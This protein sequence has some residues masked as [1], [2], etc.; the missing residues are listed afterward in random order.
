M[1]K[2]VDDLYA[3]LTDGLQLIKIGALQVDNT[4]HGPFGGFDA[5]VRIKGYAGLQ[6]LAVGTTGLFHGLEILTAAGGGDAVRIVSP[7]GFGVNVD[8]YQSALRLYGYDALQLIAKGLL[9]AGLRAQ[10]MESTGFGMF[11]NGKSIID[12]SGLNDSLCGLGTALT[13]L[14]YKGMQIES[15]GAGYTDHALTI[16]G[17][18]SGGHG[19]HV[20][21]QNS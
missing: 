19:V 1:S 11:I 14:G 10:C 20:E 21:A 3:L 18:A 2:T 15:I 4:A 17:S 13:L 5:A 12:A 6:I 9:G 16:K 7:T 8:A